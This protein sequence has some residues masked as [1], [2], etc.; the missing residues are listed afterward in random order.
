MKEQERPEQPKDMTGRQ[1]YNLISDT[2]TGPNVRLK[3]NLYQG[4]A[5]LICLVLGAGIGALVTTPRGVG[6]L[7]GGV[8]GLMVGLVGSGLFLMIYRTIQHARGRHD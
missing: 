5:I 8:I 1:V 3:D 6:V 2:V 7:L 4:L